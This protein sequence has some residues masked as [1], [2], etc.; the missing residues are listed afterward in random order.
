MTA[1]RGRDVDAAGAM[2]RGAA[3]PAAT[4]AAVAVGVSALWGA[5]A[6]VG[7]AVGAVLAVLALAAGPLLMRRVATWSPPAVMAVTTACYGATVLI[8]GAAFLV[9]S[10][11]AWLSSQHLGAALL[12][13]TVA[14]LAGQVRAVARLRVPAF[15][16]PLPGEVAERDRP[17]QGGR[18]PSSP[19]ALR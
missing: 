13:V 3:V 5:A 15:E 16:V 1:G 10:P 14:W 6:A 8:L 9:L 11:M 17:A 19:Q 2:L 18:P 7:A 4:A 12:G